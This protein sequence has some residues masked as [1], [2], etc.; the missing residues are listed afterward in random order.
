MDKTLIIA[1]KPSVAADIAK[2][3]PGK[4]SREKTHFESD[5]YI[6]SFAVGH[7][8][9]I[10][11]PEEINPGLQKW[12]LDNLPILPREFPLTV[13][14]G[15]KPQ[16]N[17]LSKLIR[18]RDVKT[19]VNGCD[20]GREGELIFKYIL[21]VASTQSVKNKEVRRLWLQSMTLDAIRD[22]INNLRS[23]EEMLPLEDTALCRSEADWLIGINATRALTCYN[24]RFGGFRKTPC[25]RVQTPT[26]SLLVKRE[27]ERR[28]FIPTTYWEL[29]ATFSCDSITYMGVWIDPDFSKD[30]A[31]PHGRQTR[32]WE[33]EKARDIADLCTGKPAKV[34]ESSK[35]T[36]KGAPPLYDLTL[37][38]REANSRFGFSAK[39]T[40]AIAQSLYER[41]KMLTY[42]RTDSRCLP[43]DYVP[44]VKKVV[45]EQTR[46]QYGNFAREA[47]DKGYIKKNKR[48]FN[49]KKVSDHHAIIP[50]TVLSR[51]L[52]EQELKIYQM[53]VQRFLAVFFPAA[54]YHNTRRLSLVENETFLT[55]GKILIV[56]GWR[57]IYGAGE[58]DRKTD[59][60]QP[61]PGGVPVICEEV[62]LQEEQTKPP[63]RYN[64]ATLLSAMEHS[65]KLVDDE[66][67]AEAMKERGLGTPATRAAIIEK[68]LNDK[69]IVREQKELVPTG[70]AV[71]LLSLLEARNIQVLASPELTGE[72]EFKLNQILKGSMTREQFM[73]EIRT[74]TGTIVDK[75]KSGE[76]SSLK[77]AA[78]SPLNGRR[79][80]ENAT[81]FESEDKKLVIRKVLGGRVMSNQE[82]V[83]LIEGK[84]LG[85]F[86]DFRSKRGKLF[87]AAVRIVNSR[88][89]F[90][91]ADST[92]EL[93]LKQIRAQEPLGRSPVDGTS[94]FETPVGFLSDSALEG[95]REKGLRISKMILGRRID[96]DHIS[97][98]L[99]DG[100]TELISGFISKKK[101]PF[102]A[103]LLLDAKGKISFEFPPRK[104]RKDGG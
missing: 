37:L 93:D 101:R 75:V 27:N 12:T 39:N 36:T 89:E 54:Q 76:K 103:F 56:P 82:I 32:I 88:V 13:L 5:K 85:P 30:K 79:F 44:T 53:V 67:L 80:F 98:L 46:W 42:P 96:S 20:A 61:L 15:T 40:L 77:E 74:I 41:H 8:V 102:D 52:S 55:E 29:Q 17:A 22:G 45:V 4:F 50:T 1:E 70:K 71:E 2:A 9:S 99:H 18:R 92:D 21:K 64:E 94:V 58:G 69:Y 86:N 51:T 97:Q 33:R 23:N 43:E 3:L 91:F 19:I 104:R 47:L 16:F 48:I 60:M 57:A 7:L 87:T 68:L 28:V 49:N 84:T 78:F 10:A 6:V 72:W 90:L 95:D 59:E 62:A 31:V 66:E 11:Y 26:L 63:P 38:Q 81:A 73:Q 25:G 14:P 35:K 34:K 100:R 65:G 83:D 24:S